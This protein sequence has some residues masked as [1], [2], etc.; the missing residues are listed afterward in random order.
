[1]FIN[2]DQRNNPKYRKSI[3]CR[4]FYKI[5]TENCKKKKKE[6]G[7]RQEVKQKIEK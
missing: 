5:L 4:D 1:M 7:K 3:L 2:L 6:K